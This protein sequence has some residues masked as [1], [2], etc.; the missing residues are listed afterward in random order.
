MTSL[1]HHLAL[2]LFAFA[3]VCGAAVAFAAVPAAPAPIAFD[4]PAADA[5]VSL[6]LFAEQSGREIVYPPEAVRGVQ[7]NAVRGRLAPRA[8]LD[9][10]VAGTPLAVV[11]SRS[12]ALA[13]NRS[14]DPNARRAAPAAAATGSIAG[15][16]TGGDGDSSLERARVTIE[17]TALET[18]T[19]AGG[20]F[21]LDGVPAGTAQVKLFYTGM[22]PLTRSVAVAA[23]QNTQLDIAMTAAGPKSTA[24]REVVKLGEFV[25]ST[26]KEMEASAI[27]INEQRFA[28][29]LKTVV[30]TDEF[31]TVAEGHVGEF[32]KFLPGVTMDYAGGNAREVSINGAPADNVPVTLDGFSLATAISGISRAAAVDM[33]SING[34]SRVEVSFSPTPDT[35]GAALA[36]SVNMIP[37]SA[38][39]RSRPVFNGS[40]YVMMRDHRKELHATPGPREDRRSK[41]PP[42]F[43][44]SWV[45]PVNKRFGFTLSGGRTSQFAGQ[46]QVTN[47]WRGAGTA[48]GG[49]FPP[50]TPDQ[51]YLSTFAV[52]GGLK[53]TT[54]HSFAATLDFKLTRYDTLS[55]SLQASRFEED[56]LSQTLTFNTGG[57]LAGNFT[58]FSTRGTTNLGSLAM[59]NGGGYRKNETY[60]PTLR[61]RHAGPVWKAEGGLGYSRARYNGADLSRGYFQSTSA[62]RNGVTVSFDDIFYLRPNR[63]TVT[64]GTTGAPLDP[65][66]LDNYAV[67]GAASGQPEN[68]DQQRTAFA[69]V[70][71]DFVW[72]VPVTLKAGLD[73]RK[74]VR[75]LRTIESR[76][77][78]FVGADG[79][80]STTPVG[81]DDAAAPFWAPE[82]STRP[83]GFGFPQIQWVGAST[84]REHYRN[85]PSHFTIDENVR[86]R[87]GVTNSKH[88]E[89]DVS[90]AFLRGD[91]ALF[92][93]RLKLVGGL[94]AEQTNIDAEGPFTDPTLNYQRDASG[95]VITVASP[96]PAEPNRRVPALL[97]PTSNALAVSQLTYLQR[98]TQVEKEY[99]RL[100]PSLNAS[101]NVRENLIVRA[102]RYS[103]VGRP[104][105]NQYAGGLTLPDPDSDAA[106][107]ANRIVVN[108][109]GIKAWS[110]ETTNA[111]LEY[112]FAGVGQI[113]VGGF[114]RDIKNFFGGTVFNATP[115]F[116]AL[117][118]LDPALYDKFD[119]TTQENLPGKVRL[120]GVDFS[121]KQALTILPSWAR[122]VQVFANAS[123]QRVT[124]DATASANFAGYIPRSGSWGVSLTRP[125]YNLRFN[126]NYRGRQ[127]RGIVATGPS[128][129]PGTYNWGS[130]RLYI[131]VSAEYSL[132]RR[133]ALFTNLRNIGDATEDTEIHGPST[134]AHA[135]FRSR[136]D[137]GSLW[138]FG[139]KGTF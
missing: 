124:G 98:G 110:A 111:R 65:Y 67:T 96:T 2:R 1:R 43:D 137:F 13:V 118:G 106:N 134:P 15:R 30:A 129:E 29:N 69:N 52:R 34:I 122:G 102:A 130:K 72:R 93:R 66:N 35:S 74:G 108:N 105:L 22:A 37:R 128:I 24:G 12:G 28:S 42:G 40:A 116:L 59:S 101:F 18:F 54:R 123:A 86:Y 50:T 138:T 95:R 113:S 20:T 27:A 89:E 92:E 47:T 7:T 104:N 31:G 39:E 83:H 45:V 56:F 73:Y 51:P 48:T 71:R 75:D 25:V 55:L 3:V 136:L 135:Q 80:A 23:D 57:V 133:I 126:W 17:G 32:L 94:R 117:Y 63:I 127:R 10:L 4:L 53:E 33:V 49:A 84:L 85:N 6:K 97:F 88:T 44:F 125:N 109:A 87:N 9:A 61:W 16:V 77:F 79:R 8:A 91:V 41:A 121:Y 78:T 81:G 36:G 46:D 76:A 5:T 100:F 112:Y 58:P 139:L 120:T 26:T 82:L 62:Q 103:S 131:D 115:E 19:D 119:V 70:S 114:Q 99:L 90:S 14:P 38:F 60:M 11:E 64:H 21:R 68:N 107:P 132:T